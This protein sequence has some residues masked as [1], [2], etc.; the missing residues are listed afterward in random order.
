MSSDHVGVVFSF[1]EAKARLTTIS[2]RDG[3][4]RFL[5]ESFVVPIEMRGVPT[6]YNQFNESQVFF[7]GP[8]IVCDACVRGQLCLQ[9]EEL[10][11]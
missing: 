1:G 4:H 2:V 6:K 8:E 7:V 9:L 5:S 3:A 11:P 10:S